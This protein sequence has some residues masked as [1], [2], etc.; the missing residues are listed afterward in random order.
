[1]PMTVPSSRSERLMAC[2]PSMTAHRTGRPS[3]DKCVIV[4]RS[5]GVSTAIGRDSACQW[6]RRRSTSAIGI[7]PS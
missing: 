4:K 6:N 1:M 3:W 7:G 2:L 5:A